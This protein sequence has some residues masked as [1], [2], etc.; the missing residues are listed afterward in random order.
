MREG[1]GE[2]GMLALLL[3]R[4]REERSITALPAIANESIGV[5]KIGLSYLTRTMS[6]IS[7]HPC[8]HTQMDQTIISMHFSYGSDIE[9][10]II[11]YQF[12]PIQQKLDQIVPH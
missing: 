4:V 11:Y 7:D 9:L 1:P 5:V 6:H 3:V 2:R 10:Y 8:I 12:V